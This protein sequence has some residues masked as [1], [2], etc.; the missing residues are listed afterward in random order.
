MSRIELVPEVLEDFER[1]LR[2]LEQFEVS[3]PLGRIDEIVQGIEILS[4]N[5]LI[6]RT[7]GGGMR[8]LVVGQGARGYVALYRFEP[9]LDIVFVL[10]LRSQKELG[11]R[12]ER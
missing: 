8:E 12:R 9:D 11:F 6:G 1:F 5:P 10:A 4:A 2:H 3:D 7:V